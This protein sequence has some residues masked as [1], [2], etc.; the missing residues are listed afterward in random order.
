MRDDVVRD[1]ER[2]GLE[3][4]AHKREQRFVVVLLGVEED[5]VERVLGRLQ[6]R[7]RIALDQLGPVVE[8]GLRDIRAPRSALRWILLER[9]EPSAEYAGSRCKLDRRVSTGPADLEHLAPRLRRGQR[10][11]EPPGRGRYLPRPL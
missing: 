1:D 10:E 4:Q 5:E 3:E 2:A 7:E 11:Q 8:P 9:G 6:R